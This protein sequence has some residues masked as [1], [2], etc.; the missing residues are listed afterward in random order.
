[1]VQSL[2]CDSELDTHLQV[3][4]SEASRCHAQELPHGVACNQKEVRGMDVGDDQAY[5]I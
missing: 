4:T 2:H 3:L 5:M 1:M